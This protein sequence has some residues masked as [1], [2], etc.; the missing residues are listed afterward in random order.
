MFCFTSF[1]SI[2][3]RAIHPRLLFVRPFLSVLR[4]G[5]FLSEG[6]ERRFF[7]NNCVV[8]RIAKDGIQVVIESQDKIDFYGLYRRIFDLISKYR[9]HSNTQ[10]K[11]Q[12]EEG[13]KTAYLFTRNTWNDE[14]LNTAKSVSAALRNL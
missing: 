1:P 12:L 9:K 3:S 8:R 2:R 10:I 7:K 13:E 4:G 11:W 14:H 6:S 5:N